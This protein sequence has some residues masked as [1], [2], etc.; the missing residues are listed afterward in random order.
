MLWQ[1]SSSVS[2][3]C[4]YPHLISAWHAGKTAC[5]FAVAGYKLDVYESPLLCPY[6]SPSSCIHP[7]SFILP[8]FILRHLSCL[9]YPPSFVLPHLSSLIYP[10]SFTAPHLSHLIYPPSF[11][12]PHFSS[13]IFPPSSVLCPLPSL[14][15]P[16]LTSVVNAFFQVRHCWLHA[17]AAVSARAAHPTSPL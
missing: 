2:P 9:T 16:P 11:I 6:N 15:F 1:Q 17:V 14:I 4:K 8:L 10:P 12:L 13:L 3:P 5:K 7:T